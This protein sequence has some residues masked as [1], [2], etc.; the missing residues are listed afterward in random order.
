VVEGQGEAQIN[1]AVHPLRP[2]DILV[3]PS[4]KRMTFSAE[5][6][7][8]LFGFSNKATQQKLNLYK[9]HRE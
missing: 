3:A 6:D 8:V 5:R 2:R 7:L 9:E 4:W 1:D